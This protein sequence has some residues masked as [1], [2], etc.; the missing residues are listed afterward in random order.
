ESNTRE[1][2]AYRL[3]GAKLTAPR[4]LKKF[5]AGEPDGLRTDRDGK[6]FLARN[7]NGIVAVLTPDGQQV[8]QVHTVGNKPSNP[9]FGGPDGRTVFVT[10]VDG[11]FIE[12]FRTD[13]PGRE[14]CLQ[15][16]GALC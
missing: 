16:S 11:R 1:L 3:D 6:I 9:R 15:F 5:D 8:H 14:P 10:Q 12:S 4:R 2:W 13:R 7:G